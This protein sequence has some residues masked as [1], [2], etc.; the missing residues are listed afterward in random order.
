MKKIKMM[1]LLS[2][3]FLLITVF[4]V[5]CSENNEN[6]VPAPVPNIAQIVSQSPNFSTLNAAVAKAGLGDALATTQN[7]TVFAPD[8][9]AFAAS[10]ITS[11]DG[12]TA[13]QLQAILLYHVF[14]Q[15]VSSSAIPVSD[16]L[17]SLNTANIYASRNVNGVF[18]NGFK[19]KQAD[20]LGSN[21]VIHVIEKVMIPPTQTIAQIAAADTTLSFLVTALTNTG[22]LPAVQAAGKLTVFAPTN[23]AF[24]DAGITDVNALPVQILEPI[25][26]YHV[27]G[28]NVFSSDLVNGATAVT[29]QGGTVTVTATPT[30]TVKITTSAQ[31]ASPITAA[32]I[33]AK[34]GVVHKIGRVMIP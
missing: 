26:K 22:L 11:V 28:T 8:N 2:A 6:T 9:A 27:L 10:G 24:R 3:V 19:V 13:A 25:L 29:L 15:K 12:F 34:N 17:K 31:P 32:N 14:G 20:I 5:S 30:A 33:V 1:R 21:G 7:I 18:T 4:M 16:T 23:Q